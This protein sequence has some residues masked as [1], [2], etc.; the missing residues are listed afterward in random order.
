[1]AFSNYDDAQHND[2]RP[3][4][5]DTQDNNTQHKALYTGMLSVLC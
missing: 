3:N 1:M 2:T 4:N 5:R